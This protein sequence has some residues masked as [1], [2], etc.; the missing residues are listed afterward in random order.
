MIIVARGGSRKRV[1]N[2][3]VSGQL[4]GPGVYLF[5]APGCDTCMSA[6]RTCRRIVGEGGVTELSRKDHRKL[7]AELRVREVPTVLVVDS[8]GN[9]VRSFAENLTERGLRRAVR[10]MET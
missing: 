4:A 3:N 5:K 7:F 2:L 9:E 8:D 6:R 1:P 10:K